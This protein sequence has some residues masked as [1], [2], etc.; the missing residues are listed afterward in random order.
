M[1]TITAEQKSK[2]LKVINVFETGKP[3]GVYD[4]ITTLEDGPVINGK[5]IKQITYGRSQTTEFGNLKRLLETY[6]SNKGVFAND[7]APYMNRI[8]V[9]ASLYTDNNFRNLLKR[10]AKEDVIMRNSQD[11]FFDTYYYQPALFWF[12]GNKFTKALSLLVIYDSFIHSGRILEFLRQRFAA[13]PPV[14]GG[15][16]EEWIK[17][18]VDV[19]AQWLATHTNPI[20]R[21][22][23]YRTN[24]FAAQ[25]KAGNWDLSKDIDAN[26]TII[27]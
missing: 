15:S 1:A 24:C 10:A 17:Q 26:R 16:E 9:G 19:R 20:L 25:I 13:K 3:D 27:K 18:Y 2:I 5:R 4:S 6:I 12:E 14:N 11:N 7:F 8:G 21:K 22:T 23:I